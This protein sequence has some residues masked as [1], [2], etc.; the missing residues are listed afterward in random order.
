MEEGPV[1]KLVHLPREIAREERAPRFGEGGVPSL[2]DVEDQHVLRAL[3]LGASKVLILG[4]HHENC[5]Y[6]NGST[7]AT[8]NVD[9][10]IAKLEKAGFEGNRLS[11]GTLASIEPE[12][13][14][15]FVEGTRK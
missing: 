2:Q 7:R 6:L 11:V 10:L 15:D 9:A 3:E 5:H 14:I 12:K 8:R 13:F 4:C 1:L